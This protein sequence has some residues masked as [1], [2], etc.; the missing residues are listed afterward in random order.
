VNIF[1]ICLDLLENG[2]NWR[3]D[4]LSSELLQNEEKKKHSL[5]K[6]APIEL[7]SA[8]PF[9]FE[10]NPFEEVPNQISEE[11][12]E[13][14]K[15]AL[16]NAKMS[17]FKIQE[18]QPFELF[19]EAVNMMVSDEKK[20][21]ENVKR[22]EAKLKEEKERDE[23]MHVVF[24]ERAKEIE[25]IVK[26]KMEQNTETAEKGTISK[27]EESNPFT[28]E[29]DKEQQEKKQRAEKLQLSIM[30]TLQ[31]IQ[32]STSQLVETSRKL[33]DNEASKGEENPFVSFPDHSN[34]SKKEEASKKQIPLQEGDLFSF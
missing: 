34:S 21:K 26:S 20:M 30:E 13:K 9:S 25:K 27:E 24:V 16:L 14:Q 22:M 33:G 2:P 3:F 12:L 17:S 23:K 15:K 6:Q 1:Q 11:E 28:P 32:T 5:Q 10:T 31:K 29:V 4:L 19:V 8:T 7:K 18:A